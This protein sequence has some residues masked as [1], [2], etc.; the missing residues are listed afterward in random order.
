[1][2]FSITQQYFK[3]G[4]TPQYLKNVITPLLC[5][6]LKIGT[7]S[8]LCNILK[9][10]T[11]PLLRN[12]L[13]IGNTPLLSSLLKAELLHHSP[14]SFARI[15]YVVRTVGLALYSANFMAKIPLCWDS[16]KSQ[17]FHIWSL[18]RIKFSYA[19]SLNRKIFQF[20]STYNKNQNEVFHR[21]Y[22]STTQ[23]LSSTKCTSMP[24]R[25]F[26]IETANPS[27]IF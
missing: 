1:M 3:S 2:N 14:Y 6:F 10:G 20:S 27:E 22:R 16:V 26:W 21:Y 4:T 9:S 12:I 19:T 8:L 11:T 24:Q 7:T 13:K 5:N 25:R 15:C 23:I 17:H 18:Q